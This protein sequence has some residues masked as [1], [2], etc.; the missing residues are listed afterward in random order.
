MSWDKKKFDLECARGGVWSGVE[1]RVRI[2]LCCERE[3]YGLRPRAY[4]EMLVV[5]W[6]GIESIL[7]SDKKKK[8]KS[9]N[10]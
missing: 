4:G 10:I 8:E 5:M 2:V 7:L 1:W 6:I 3:E 9:C